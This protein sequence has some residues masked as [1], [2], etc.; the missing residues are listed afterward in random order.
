MKKIVLMLL[1]IF[2]LA[3]TVLAVE[4]KDELYYKRQ[5]QNQRFLYNESG[6]FN[7]IQKGN[8]T[9]VDAFLKSGMSPNAT[10]SGTPAPMYALFFNQN[11][12]FELIMS[13][14]ANPETKVPA[15]WVSLKPQNLLSFAIKRKNSEA[16][17]ILIK[18]DVDINKVFNGKTPLNYAI[19]KKQ[20]KI[21]GL[22]LKAGAKPD[23]KTRKL[24]N[25]S[26]DEYLK[27]L[28]TNI[29]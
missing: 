24:I 29:L 3:N 23:E 6:F 11:E 25:K 21:V 20:T 8:A 10:L 15:C 27:D 2:C 14:G 16:V 12:I 28:F 13:A 19:S 26:T 9:V 7:A 4:V 1:V 17:K 18:N 22:L 5:I